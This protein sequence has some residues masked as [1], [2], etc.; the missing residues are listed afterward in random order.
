MLMYSSLSS[1]HT[2][3]SSGS[4]SDE[5]RGSPAADEAVSA[6]LVHSG[7]VARRGRTS[8]QIDEDRITVIIVFLQPI[9]GLLFFA[10][11]FFSF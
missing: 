4:G 2:Q 10:V 11:F 7:R 8:E 1:S 9:I 5:S 3:K 6:Q